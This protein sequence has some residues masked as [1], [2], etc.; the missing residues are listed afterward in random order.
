MLT[1]LRVAKS[2]KFYYIFI[3]FTQFFLMNVFQFF[4]LGK[5]L[6]GKSFMSLEYIVCMGNN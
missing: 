2:L 3:S 5:C 4:I 1:S 6:L